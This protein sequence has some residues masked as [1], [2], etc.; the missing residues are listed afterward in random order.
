MQRRSTS[1]L[2]ALALLA[3]TLFPFASIPL[4]CGSIDTGGTGGS[5]SGSGGAPDA[6]SMRVTVTLHP[7][8]PPLPGESACTV[9]E[10]TNLA[11][12]DA[13]HVATC[14]PVEYA[15]D[16]PSGGPHWPVWAARGKYTTPVPRPMYVHD[17]EHGW[18]V[19]SYRCKDDCPD[20]VA[21]LEKAFDTADDTYCVAHGDANARVIL[22]PDPLLNTP[23]AASAWGATYTATC[24]DP[25]SIADFIAKRIGRGT[26][27]ICGGGQLPDLVSATC[28]GSSSTGG[29]MD[30]G[31]GGG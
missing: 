15:T 3:G 18:I 10:V 16:P 4:G 21:A 17:L 7:S 12:P 1:R 14:T 25:A 6:G 13:R 28:I 29:D 24:I 30:A 20:V 23:I 2:R 8:A 27:M 19:L 5:G 26:E 31:D 11:I 22:T 9:V